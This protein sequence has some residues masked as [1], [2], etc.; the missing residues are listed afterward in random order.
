[1]HTQI[2]IAPRKSWT[3]NVCISCV[4]GLEIHDDGRRAPCKP[5]STPSD[6]QAWASSQKP[7]VP[8][9]GSASPAKPTFWLGWAW[10]SGFKFLS[11]SQAMKP[12]FEID[13]IDVCQ[14]APASPISYIFTCKK[15]KL[16]YHAGFNSFQVNLG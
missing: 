4:H 1:M 3:I 13:N 16:P 14:I 7:V 6:V 2:Q 8:S 15:D 12:G 5:R 10:A 11:P 9:H